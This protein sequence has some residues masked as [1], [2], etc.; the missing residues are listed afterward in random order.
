L[1]TEG[2]ESG[3]RNVTEL[4]GFLTVIELDGEWEEAPLE[5]I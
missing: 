3:T 5:E 1:F 4:V 2:E